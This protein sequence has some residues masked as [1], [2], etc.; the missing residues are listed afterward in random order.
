MA[1]T[2]TERTKTELPHRHAIPPGSATPGPRRRPGSQDRSDDQEAG[3]AG[4]NHQTPDDDGQTTTRSGPPEFST[5]PQ[6]NAKKA[7]KN[8]KKQ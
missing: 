2:G 1:R 6:P 7:Q 3:S 5:F 4:P 8:A